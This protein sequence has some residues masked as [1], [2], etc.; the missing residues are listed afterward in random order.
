MYISLQATYTSFLSCNNY[1]IR[2]IN[3]SIS[4]E[5][6]LSTGSPVLVNNISEKDL[7]GSQAVVY[8]IPTLQPSKYL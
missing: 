2:F 1:I 7:P 4:T 5:L 8:K 6:I 3:F